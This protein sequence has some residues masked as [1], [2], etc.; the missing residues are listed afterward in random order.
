MD[1]RATRAFVQD[2]RSLPN[3][4][5]PSDH[6]W[7]EKLSHSNKGRSPLHRLSTAFTSP[8][9]RQPT[10]TRESREVVCLRTGAVALEFMMVVPCYRSGHEY[11]SIDKAV[12]ILYTLYVVSA[13]KA[14]FAITHYSS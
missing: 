10:P 12:D 3:N 13:G 8:K 2:I 14:A 11:Y 4:T 1:S 6:I 5:W 9:K 7:I